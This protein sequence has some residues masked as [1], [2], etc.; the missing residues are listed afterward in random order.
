[1]QNLNFKFLVERLKVKRTD[2][3]GERMKTQ[4]VRKGENE[5]V[6]DEKMKK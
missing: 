2:K 4:R 6:Q 1:M 3:K 5:R